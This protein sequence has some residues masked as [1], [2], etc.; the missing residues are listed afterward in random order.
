[1]RKKRQD[2]IMRWLAA[3]AIDCAERRLPP[4]VARSRMLTVLDRVDD[5]TRAEVTDAAIALIADLPGPPS[6][7]ALE[8]ERYDRWQTLLGGR[9]VGEQ[10]GDL[11]TARVRLLELR[12]HLASTRASRSTRSGSTG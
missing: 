12:D 1:M 4:V 10:L 5:T 9:T 8:A 7:P 3:S 6:L 2:S 11:L